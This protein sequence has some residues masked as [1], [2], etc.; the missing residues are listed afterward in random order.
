MIGPPGMQFRPQY[1]HPPVP[2]GPH[3]FPHGP[4]GA[5]HGDR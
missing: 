1:G 3:F 4:A 2:G 5:I